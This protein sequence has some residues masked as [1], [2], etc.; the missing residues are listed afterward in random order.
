MGRGHTHIL[1]GVIQPET[2][3]QEP[4][5]HFVKAG[6][7][8]EASYIEISRQGWVVEGVDGGVIRV[9][10]RHHAVPFEDVLKR[11]RVD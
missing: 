10:V 1:F 3:S 2:V 6:D 4:G 11:Q 5:F 7:E 9:F 8:S